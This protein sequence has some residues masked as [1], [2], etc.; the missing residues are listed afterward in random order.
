MGMVVV[1]RY[2]N[3]F[4]G[5]ICCCGVLYLDVWIIGKIVVVVHCYSLISH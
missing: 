3:S 2:M 1:G 4:R 5:V